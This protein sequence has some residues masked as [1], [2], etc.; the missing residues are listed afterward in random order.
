VH[1]RTFL[2]LIPQQLPE[3]MDGILWH[4]PLNDNWLLADY[5]RHGGGFYSYANAYWNGGIVPL[6]GFAA[7]LAWLIARVEM[8]FKTLPVYYGAAYFLLLLVVPVGFYYG[9]QGLV[10]GIE[11]GIVAF[12]AIRF[13]SNRMIPRP[14]VDVR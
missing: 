3:A 13:I 1:Y 8:F 5:F 14:T 11:Y 4:R 7:L 9:I 2:N 10:R 12:L 6:G